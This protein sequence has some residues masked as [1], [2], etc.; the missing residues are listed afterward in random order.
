[1]GA[2]ASLTGAAPVTTVATRPAVGAARNGARSRQGRTQMAW[3]KP[4][5]VEISVA[6]EIN[7]YACADIG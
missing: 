6:L 4:R 3:T 1:M 7:C 2:A 5:V